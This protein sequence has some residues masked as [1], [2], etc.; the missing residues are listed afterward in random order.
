MRGRNERVWHYSSGRF[1]GVWRDPVAAAERKRYIY[2][3]YAQLQSRTTAITRPSLE[4]AEQN[5][6]R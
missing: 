1:L 5:R 6:E 4:R 3:N 2:V